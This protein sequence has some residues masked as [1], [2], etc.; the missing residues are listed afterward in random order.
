[1]E[2]PKVSKTARLTAEL[3][4]IAAYLI[5][6]KALVLS[7]AFT[8]PGQGF[9][10][11]FHDGTLWLLPFAPAARDQALVRVLAKAKR[12]GK[13][14]I[15]E[16][17]TKAYVYKLLAAAEELDASGDATAEVLTRNDVSAMR[18]RARTMLAF[19][20]GVVDMGDTTAVVRRPIPRDVLFF[21]DEVADAELPATDAAFWAISTT[22]LE[23]VLE[24]ILC[25]AWVVV[26]DAA[27][28]AF[29]CIPSKPEG[30][31]S[32][33]LILFYSAARS[34]FKSAVVATLFGSALPPARCPAPSIPAF[35]IGPKFSTNEHSDLAPTRLE[36]KRNYGRSII[37][38]FDEVDNHKKQIDLTAVKSE[39][40]PYGCLKIEGAGGEVQVSTAPL[41]IASTNKSPESVFIQTPSEEESQYIFVLDTSHNLFA[42]DIETLD[43]AEKARRDGLTAWLLDLQRHAP[44]E[45]KKSL[46]LQVARLAAGWLLPERAA[47]RQSAAEL[48]PTL[49]LKAHRAR[50]AEEQLAENRRLNEEVGAHGAI[51]ADNL[52]SC[53]HAWLEQNEHR[54]TSDDHI[55]GGLRRN[56]VYKA[57]GL[58][59]SIGGQHVK[60]FAAALDEWVLDR[61]DVGA[62]MLSG[63]YPGY[64]GVRLIPLD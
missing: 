14:T 26:C 25:E 52:L 38:Y 37:R 27:V 34:T 40:T 59:L 28:D 58:D 22:Q 29:R 62:V 6:S 53:F 13:L 10:W 1:V 32:K 56:E 12:E 54:F 43:E 39:Q 11:W 41:Y 2:E 21:S 44:P 47:E 46:A 64:K 30:G 7:D 20:G 42:R 61:Y 3:T 18:K 55:R 9:K 16:S 31:G 50:K 15:D 57:A 36:M 33:S 4:A 60:L 35:M 23:V 8:T 17:P 19:R 63:G 51:E 5:E 45:V 48:R 24:A 49:T